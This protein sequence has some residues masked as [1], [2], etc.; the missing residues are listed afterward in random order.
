MSLGIS[1]LITFSSLQNCTLHFKKKYEPPPAPKQQLRQVSQI[2][3]AYL[4][5]SNTP[6]FLPTLKIKC[7][8]LE[9]K[10]VIIIR[11]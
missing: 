2:H 6:F 7:E 10:I 3:H 1:D 4:M 5:S 8:I 11:K 9:K